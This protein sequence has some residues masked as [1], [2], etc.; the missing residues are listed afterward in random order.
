MV[1]YDTHSMFEQF[2]SGYYLGE[3][4]VEPHDGE[5]AILNREDHEQVNEQLYASGEGLE[6]LDTP[7]VMKLDGMHFPVLGDDEVPSGTLELPPAYTDRRLPASRQVFL[8]KADRAAELLGYSG[9]KAAT[10]T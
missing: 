3:L 4:Y 5:F 8:A 7:L 10:G 1:E 2:S 9:W 6:R